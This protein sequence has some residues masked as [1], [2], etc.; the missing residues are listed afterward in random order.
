MDHVDPRLL[1]EATEEGDRWERSEETN[2]Y[3][4]AKTIA[5]RDRKNLVRP[6][7]L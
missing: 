7:L 2:G 4:G 1:E 5:T 3:E 6:F